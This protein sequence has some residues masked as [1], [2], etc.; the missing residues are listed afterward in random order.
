MSGGNNWKLQCA[1]NVHM[2][3]MGSTPHTIENDAHCTRHMP[4][5]VN[6][7]RKCK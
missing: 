5:T 3:G 4:T 6:R 1:I 7:F 2:G